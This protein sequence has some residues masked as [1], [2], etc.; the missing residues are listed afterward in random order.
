[1]LLLKLVLFQNV[2]EEALCPRILKAAIPAV[3]AA[4][5]TVAGVVMAV[6]APS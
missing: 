2:Q 6:P 5:A 3:A 1:V 4:A